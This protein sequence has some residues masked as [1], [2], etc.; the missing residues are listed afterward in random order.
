MST[1]LKAQQFLYTRATCPSVNKRRTMEVVHCTHANETRAESGE[2]GDRYGTFPSSRVEYVNM[3]QL[4]KKGNTRPL[5]TSLVERLNARGASSPGQPP[6]ITTITTLLLS[7]LSYP[8]LR[9]PL[10]LSFPSSAL[11]VCVFVTQQQQE[12]PAADILPA[13]C[14]TTL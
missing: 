1:L 3:H 14:T 11:T 5:P 9:I 10:F 13:G 2:I 4:R 8:F 12:N 7:A 6:T